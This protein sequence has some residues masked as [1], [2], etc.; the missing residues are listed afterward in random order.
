MAFITWTKEMS[1]SVTVLDEDHK[2]LIEIINQLHDGISAGHKKEILA[3]VLDELAKYTKFHFDREE[4]FFAKSNYLS[5]TAHKM[6]HS[7]FIS[8]LS[9]LQE[10]FKST[11]IAMLDLELMSYLRNW[12][13]MHIQGSDKKY[14]PHLNGCGIS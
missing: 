9:N 6:E 5:T 1:V 14:G 7:G 4:E 11:P 3:S 10:R 12:L 8:R 2:K 13:L